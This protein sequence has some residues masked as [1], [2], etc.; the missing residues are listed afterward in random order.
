M[1]AYLVYIAIRSLSDA[2]YGTIFSGL[3]LGVHEAGHVLFSPF[4]ELLEVAGG[5]LTQIAVPLIV[6]LLFLRQ[7]EYFGIAVALAW[8][9]LSLS[10][11]ATYIGDARDQLLPLVSMGSGDPIHDWHFLLAHFGMLGYDR[12]LA[13]FTDFVSAL[14]LVA[15]LTLGG[16]LCAAMHRT[17]GEP[18]PADEGLASE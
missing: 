16:W 9:S 10:G 4:G 13:R 5:S 7:R 11:L 17:A 6:A 2:E 8:L 3:T 1:L 12:A 18:P 14:S 15:A